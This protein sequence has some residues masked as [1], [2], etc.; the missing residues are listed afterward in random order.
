MKLSVQSAMVEQVDVW[1]Q[2]LTEEERLAAEAMSVS[3]MRARYEI[4]RGLRRKM[5]AEASGIA[6]VGLQF[7]ADSRGKPSVVNAP[8]WHFNVSHSGGCVVC[9]VSSVAVG[10]DVEQVRTVRE[11][12]AIVSR[13][14]HTDEASALRAVDSVR[15]VQGFFRLWTA[16]E[17]A[18][19][20][21]GLGLA[22]G[23]S[24]TRVDPA[25]LHAETAS[26]LVGECALAVEHLHVPDGYVGMVA[27][28]AAPQE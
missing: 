2:R 9:A 26:A 3:L 21:C 13:Y 25:I 17:A 22:R 5:L 28:S 20:C 8:G 15:Q 27:Y 7:G 10:I 19:K 24:V 12:D 6:A 14:F 18:V 11:Q 16:R 23:M 1:R 4:G